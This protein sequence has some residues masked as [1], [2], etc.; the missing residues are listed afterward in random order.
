M[1]QVNVD[2]A[3]VQCASPGNAII[4]L[5]AADL[6]ELLSVTAPYQLASVEAHL[7]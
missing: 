4:P 1:R 5:G 6:E 7:T 3:G 2:T